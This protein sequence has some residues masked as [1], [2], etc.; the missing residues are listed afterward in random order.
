MILVI[1]LIW[2]VYKITIP[3]F[4]SLRVNY[5]NVLAESNNCIPFFTPFGI[6]CTTALGIFIYFILFFAFCVLC[7]VSIISFIAGKHFHK[8]VFYISSVSALVAL[9]VCLYYNYYINN[10]ADYA[11]TN[12]PSNFISDDVKKS[13]RNE[14]DYF[15][16]T[17]YMYISLFITGIFFGTFIAAFICDQIFTSVVG[18][19]RNI[20]SRASVNNSRNENIRRRRMNRD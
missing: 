14:F 19:G 8:N 9:L 17:F 1:I 6:R 5:T 3:D 13:G 16:R 15:S 20:G 10:I 4:D 2:Q 11:V 12:I 7:G 18:I